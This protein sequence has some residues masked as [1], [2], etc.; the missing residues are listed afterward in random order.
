[1]MRPV[2]GRLTRAPALIPPAALRTF[3]APV[4]GTAG[5]RRTAAPADLPLPF[6]ATW[7]QVKAWYH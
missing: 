2:P 7:G 5:V 3:G 4:T 1:M 6:Y